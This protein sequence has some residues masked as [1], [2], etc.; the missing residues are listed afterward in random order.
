MSDTD[1]PPALAAAIDNMAPMS[2]Q[3][4]AASRHSE[5][6]ATAE[7]SSSVLPHQYAPQAVDVESAAVAEAEAAAAAAAQAATLSV[8]CVL[9][10]GEEQHL[11]HAL[12]SANE[13]SFDSVVAPLGRP[14]PAASSEHELSFTE[15][16]TLMSASRWA[17]RVLGQSSTWIRLDGLSGEE[18]RL[19]GQ[20]AHPD[21]ALPA[22][23]QRL[24]SEAAFRREVSW[25]VHLSLPAILVPNLSPQR[26]S[27]AARCISQALLQSQFLQIWVQV[28]LMAPAEPFSLSSGPAA[29]AEAAS[30]SSSTSAAASS[31]T[32]A[33]SD[34]SDPWLAW[35]RVRTAC[36][37]HRR[38]GVCLEIG[39]DLPPFSTEAQE[40]LLDH[41][42]QEDATEG[43]TAASGISSKS[44]SAHRRGAEELLVS[45]WLGEPVR[46]LM[47]SS[48]VFTTN[49]RGFPVLSKRHQ[50]LLARFFEIKDIVI[51]VRDEQQGTTS[52]PFSVDPA[53]PAAQPPQSFSCSSLS[54]HQYYL[55]HL[56]SKHVSAHWTPARAFALPYRDY[57]QAP[58]QPLADN[59]ESGVYEVFE[60][61]PVKYKKYEEAV[62]EALKDM[63]LPA[64]TTC[65]DA[66][67]ESKGAMISSSA[68]IAEVLV[69]GAGRGPLVRCVLRAG[70]SAGVRVRVHALE[71]N[72]NAVLTLQALQGH[73]PAFKDVIVV[74]TD[75][76][77]WQG[78]E[79]ASKQQSSSSG[80]GSLAFA[81]LVVSELLGSFGDNELSPECLEPILQRFL[82]PATGVSIP[83]S[84]Q[85]FLVPVS[86]SRLWGDVLAH[87]AGSSSGELKAFETSYVCQMHNHYRASQHIRPVFNF[88]HRAPPAPTT[89]ITTAAAG[90]DAGAASAAAERAQRSSDE[91][92][93]GDWLPQDNPAAVRRERQRRE[94][95]QQP[96]PSNAALD[97]ASSAAT[98]AV[99]AVAP[100]VSLSASQLA[101]ISSLAHSRHASLSFPI[102]LA[103]TVHGLGGYF[104]ARLYKDVCISIVP[105][106]SFST[107]M[108]SWFPLFFPLR[109]PVALASGDTLQVDMWRCTTA[110][111]VWYEWALTGSGSGGQG[112][113]G[114]GAVSPVHN[115][116][117][118][119]SY[120]GL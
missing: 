41:V 93:E 95:Q 118:R 102:P 87:G 68:A 70:A 57:L 52:E 61:D 5:A 44:K 115:P 88:V 90:S 103:C 114:A 37:S 40:A 45:R 84:S 14:R 86:S 47:L 74:S 81:D 82:K 31:S 10:G 72:P 25:A 73:D 21:A 9:R 53:A 120:I 99:A 105:G 48:D 75:A 24:L 80:G 67:E 101:S 36:E 13:C 69:V 85:S 98:C 19:H 4:A 58:L 107:G 30:S 32:P 46:A 116:N 100:A 62:H 39:A 97:H 1:M 27:N 43:L 92:T 89:T 56:F 7:A 33:H 104:T 20:G 78:P 77:E 65:A 38:L 18:N 49:A 63:F 91:H 96:A 51:L 71:K 26:C 3:A 11:L 28:P 54:A 117:G 111:K 60:R 35:D 79:D 6:S 109:T 34:A 50:T 8:G 29:S 112:A 17:H 55:R 119:S 64:N 113:T 2:A 22:H 42:S 94:Q 66:G 23:L 59:L 12:A 83:A 15:P 110:R 106:G 108:F 76:R 16:D